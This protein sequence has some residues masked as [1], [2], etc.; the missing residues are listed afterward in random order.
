MVLSWAQ[1]DSSVMLYWT[2]MQFFSKEPQATESDAVKFQQYAQCKVLANGI[3]F[4]HVGEM[5][6]ERLGAVKP[7]RAARWGSA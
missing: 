7:F 6:D 2:L 5:R 4:R 3:V 1:V